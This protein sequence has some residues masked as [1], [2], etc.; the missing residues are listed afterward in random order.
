MW[1][2]TGRCGRPRAAAAAEGADVAGTGSLARRTPRPRPP[3]LPR[4][5]GVCVQNYSCR[6]KCWEGAIVLVD[7]GKTFLLIIKR[8]F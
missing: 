4:T 3:A 1:H 7:C 2:G 8:I 6:Q 5:V